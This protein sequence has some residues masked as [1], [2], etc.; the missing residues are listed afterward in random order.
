MG[1][2]RLDYMKYHQATALQLAR[3]FDIRIVETED[4]LVLS[5]R[6]WSFLNW[7][8]LFVLLYLLYLAYRSQ[9]IDAPVLMLSITGVLLVL[10]AFFAYALLAQL[11]D[12]VVIT[13]DRVTFRNGLVWR[14]LPVDRQVEVHLR[15]TTERWTSD[16]EPQVRVISELWLIHLSKEHQLLNFES[17]K[18]EDAAPMKELGEHLKAIIHTRIG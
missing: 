5:Y 11:L 18:E 10:A 9:R 4:R 12:R 14:S 2:C 8:R 17:R 13:A 15:Q 6:R 1:S 3:K 7:F 16:S